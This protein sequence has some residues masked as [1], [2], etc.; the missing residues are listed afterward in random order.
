MV[1]KN[2]KANENDKSALT[3]FKEI[4]KCKP[5]SREE[6]YDLWKRYK[7]NHDIEARNKLVTS[8]LK[9]VASVALNYQGMGLSYSDLIM[10]GNL[11]LIR[12][13]DKFDA[14]KG[15]KAISYSVWWIRQSILEA[16]EKRNS[17]EAEDLPIENNKKEMSIESDEYLSDIEEYMDDVFVESGSSSAQKEKE[18]HTVILSLMECLNPKEKNVITKYFGLDGNEP[19]KLDEIGA[20]LSLTKERVRQ[21]CERALKKMRCDALTNSILSDI[22]N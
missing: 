17:M 9:F 2:K 8:N 5:L 13:M 18:Q 21:I 1:K 6:E 7:Y 4:Q 19:M 20:E 22:Y 11:G 12:A 10:E 15:Y 16:L 3:Y 14:S